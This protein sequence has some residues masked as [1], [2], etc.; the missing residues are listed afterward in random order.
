VHEA[1]Y[2][3]IPEAER[4][5]AHLRVG[6]TL[7][8]RTPAAELTESIFE[9]VNQLDRG[10]A[11]IDSVDERERIAEL[12]LVAGRRAKLAT[13][14]ASA[15]T[16]LAAGRAMLG[17]DAW[18]RRHRLTFDLELHLA[19]CEFLTGDLT[20]AGARL[21]RLAARADSLADRA[22]VTWLQATLWSAEGRHD[23]A[24]TVGLDF[25]RLTGVDWSPHP[26]REEVQKEYERLLQ[27][28][29]NRP[30]ESTLDL[31]AM[32][33]PDRRVVLDALTAVLPPAVFTDE[34]LN[35]LLLCRMVNISLEHGNIDGTGRR[36]LTDDGLQNAGVTF[37][38]DGRRVVFSSR[39]G[40]HQNL[41]E[42]RLDG[43]PPVQLT[44]GEG[45]D[46]SPDIAPDGRSII[47]D[48]DVTNTPI[49]AYGRDGSRRLL[50]RRT[51]DTETI[52]FAPQRARRDHAPFRHRLRRGRVGPDGRRADPR[53]GRK[54]SVH[55]RRCGGHFQSGPACPGD[56]SRRRCSPPSR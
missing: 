27:R 37:N 54:G 56:S 12:N 53:R 15:A 19:E 48:N 5:A 34:N 31:P 28:L 51:E 35:C 44:F 36:K 14:H 50:T 21:D 7:A 23:R 25:L 52:A 17:E 41:W 43:G 39:R 20:A 45:P 33:D 16:Y 47:F 38:P 2:A 9:I 13:A 32:T 3:L 40:G 46:A 26:S 1:A 18:E 49:V 30:I 42:L 29:G 22:A 6:R 8:A 4:P 10:A 24:V 11:S 55:A